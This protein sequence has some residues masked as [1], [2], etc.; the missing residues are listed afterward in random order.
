MSDSPAVHRRSRRA[1]VALIAVLA[2][3][4][5]LGVIALIPLAMGFFGASGDQLGQRVSVLLAGVIA[6]AWVAVTFLGAL[7]SRPSWARGSAVTIHVLL[8]AAGT[9]VLQYGLAP[10]WVGWAAVLVAFLGFGLGL[11]ARPERSSVEQA[12]PEDPAQTD[13]N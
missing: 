1:W 5:I 10:A 12:E 3:E 4:T 2:G 11:L 13:A 9:G 6:V 7:R 8:F